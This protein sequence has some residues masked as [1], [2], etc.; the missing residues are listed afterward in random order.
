MSVFG[1]IFG[2]WTRRRGA[3]CPEPVPALSSGTSVDELLRE[4]LVIIFKHSSACPVSWAAHAQ[5]TRFL[6]A[7]P[8]AP[9]RLLPVI[10]ERP[11][12]QR[13]AA[14]TGLRHESPQIIMLRQGAVVGSASHGAITCEGLSQ[15]L[16][17]QTEASATQ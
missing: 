1:G 2:R 13:I 14:A 9:V 12:S 3:A 8:G 7:N 4:E 16:R 17:G 11:L 15:M 10:K 6:R 5:V